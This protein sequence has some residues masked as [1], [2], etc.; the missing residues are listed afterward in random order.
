M[1]KILKIQETV[2]TTQEEAAA[3]KE[4]RAAADQAT[5]EKLSPREKLTQWQAVI[6]ENIDIN[7]FKSWDPSQQQELFRQVNE[8][9][10]QCHASGDT[11]TPTF[12]SI[13]AFASTLRK[14]IVVSL[15]GLRD[16]LK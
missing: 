8:L 9:I 15:K 13:E 2:K 11:S 1:D 10:E 4:A 7:T 14:P 16:Q 6:S 12:E 5:Y 3:E